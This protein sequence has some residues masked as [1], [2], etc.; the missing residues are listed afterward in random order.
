MQALSG[1]GCKR[2]KMNTSHL[3]IFILDV[4]FSNSY[5]L[6]HNAQMFAD[7]CMILLCHCIVTPVLQ[8]VTFL[9]Q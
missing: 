5:I 1:I 9:L 3:T 8:D 4:V 6:R 2:H 7:I